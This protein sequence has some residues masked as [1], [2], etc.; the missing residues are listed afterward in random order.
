MNTGNGNELS[1]RCLNETSSTFKSVIIINKYTYTNNGD[2]D[3]NCTVGVQTFAK[4]S[5][6]EKENLIPSIELDVALFDCPRL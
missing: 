6:E 5:G 3:H 4:K 2:G 1:E